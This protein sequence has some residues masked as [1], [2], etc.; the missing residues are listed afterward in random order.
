MDFI[1]HTCFV[2]YAHGEEIIMKSFLEQFIKVLNGHLDLYID[3]KIYCDEDRVKPG[4]NYNLAL[5]KAIC[6]SVCMIVLF[7]P[8]YE[9]SLYCLREFLAMEVLERQRAQLL[10]NAYDNTKRII[11]PIILRGRSEDIPQKIRSIH[12]KDFRNLQL[13]GRRLEEDQFF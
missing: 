6:K 1:E 9:R 2:S 11:I 3:E 10:G 13:Y 5:A 8:K 12:F 4:Y 7:D